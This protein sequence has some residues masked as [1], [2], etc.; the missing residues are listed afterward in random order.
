MTKKNTITYSELSRRYGYD[1]SVISRQWVQKGLDITKSEIEINKWINTNIMDPLRNTDIKEQIE[2]KRLEKLTAESALVQLELA[3]RE[4]TVVSTE[5]VETILTNYLFQIKNTIR[6]IP[7]KVY[8]ELF[9]MDDAKDLRDK[10]KEE[11]DKT[12][13]QLGEMDFELPDDKDIIDEPEQDQDDSDIEPDDE[14][15]STAEDSENE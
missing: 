10:L 6:S 15:D 4:N 3:E 2:V 13:Y 11:I 12:L 1:V 7:S 8:L 9:A 14:D 5:Y